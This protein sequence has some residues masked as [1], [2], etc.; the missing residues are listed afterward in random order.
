M[1]LPALAKTPDGILMG[2]M[3][4]MEDR[5]TKLS[6]DQILAQKQL[7]QDVHEKTPNYNLSS[8][9]FWFRI[10]VQNI[11]GRDKSLFLNLQAPTID[12]VTLHVIGPGNRH[13]IVYSGDRVPAEKRPVP[14]ATTSVMPFKILSGES[15]DLYI[16]VQADA[17]ALVCPFAIMDGSELE[18]YLFSIR[19][20]HGIILGLFIALIIHNLLLYL[21]LKERSRLYYLLY[22]PFCFLG[23]TTIN[24]FGSTFL[25]PGNVWLG[26]EGMPVFFGV[27]LFFSLLFSRVFRRL[28]K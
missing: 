16:R 6:F 4:V 5:S 19:S 1:V 3:Q 28:T 25:Y 21:M 8:W 18:D 22:L 2:Q 26:N 23:F 14:Y 12:H 7:F 11:S 13:D 10:P 15:I 27:T 9:A 24:G 17:G 20:L